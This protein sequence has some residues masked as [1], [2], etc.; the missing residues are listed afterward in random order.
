MHSHATNTVE[1]E[2]KV[3]AAKFSSTF[4][5]IG[6]FY[7]KHLTV[8]ESEFLIMVSQHHVMAYLVD[9]KVS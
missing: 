3:N 8:S 4:V 5:F 1:S 9:Y 7:S 2:L 6:L